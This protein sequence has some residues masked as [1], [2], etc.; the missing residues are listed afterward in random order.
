MPR[1]ADTAD[2]AVSDGLAHWEIPFVTRG[3]GQPPATASGPPG[4]VRKRSSTKAKPSCLMSRSEN[5][6]V[7]RF[8]LR[9]GGLLSRHP[10]G[11]E[12]SDQAG[13]KREEAMSDAFEMDVV[14]GAG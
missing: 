8:T 1:T 2:F 3:A 12:R 5:S 11:D 6:P 14:T 10:G 7:D 13:E 4:K 9:R